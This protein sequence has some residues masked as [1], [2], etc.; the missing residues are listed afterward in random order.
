[1]IEEDRIS[2]DLERWWK[3]STYIA[4]QWEGYKARKFMWGV[5][6]DSVKR[7]KAFEKI[8]MK[9][10]MEEAERRE[11][12]R[13]IEADRKEEVVIMIQRLWR[14]HLAKIRYQRK[15]LLTF[16]ESTMCVVQRNVRARLGR[17]RCLARC[18]WLVMRRK[19]WWERKKMAIVLRILGF[20]K[21][22]SQENLMESLAAFGFHPESYN[23]NP[24]IVVKQ[25]LM[26]VI[27]AKTAVTD[28]IKLFG[29][30][31][32][33]ERRRAKLYGI[34]AR[35]RHARY[36][37]QKGHAVKIIAKGTRRRGETGYVVRVDSQGRHAEKV[38]MIKLD[39]DGKIL[40]M[41]YWDGGTGT[42]ESRPNMQ[43]VCVRCSKILRNDGYS[44]KRC[45]RKYRIQHEGF[46]IMDVVKVRENALKLRLEGE[47]MGVIFREG[48]AAR[49]VQRAFRARRSA[50]K[51]R[52][53]RE[54]IKR[55]R[56]KMIHRYK[57]VF[58]CLKMR[59]RGWREWFID[60]KVIHERLLPIELYPPHSCVP[61]WYTRRKIANREAKARGLEMPV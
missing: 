6:L 18:R 31:G 19:I 4:W 38:L 43:I 14:G 40:R 54:K 16:Y 57:V 1:M 48:W 3:A 17:L 5:R 37:A 60:K 21:K 47:R 41:R 28:Q 7:K 53:L 59:T 61:K 9:E 11:Q 27:V 29:A 45:K 42:D 55:Y 56:I 44:C 35:K 13:E 58:G 15:W 52:R 32:F 30:G 22:Q 10:I 36:T 49:V 20:R 2:H 34:I 51:S 39:K 26:D 50:R 8:R 23:L 24:L 25:I 33:N 46:P 12:Q